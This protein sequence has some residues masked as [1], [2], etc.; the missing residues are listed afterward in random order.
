MSVPKKHYHIVV[1][2]LATDVSKEIL[3]LLDSQ[4]LLGWSAYATCRRRCQQLVNYLKKAEVEVVYTS[5]R[6][7]VETH[8]AINTK[9]YRPWETRE[10]QYGLDRTR[11]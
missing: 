9:K 5:T 11:K 1:D 6:T 7:C 4:K 3:E 2:I 10:E 8:C